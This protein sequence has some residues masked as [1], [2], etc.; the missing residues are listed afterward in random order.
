MVSRNGVSGS[1][2][3]IDM[4]YSLKLGSKTYMYHYKCLKKVFDVMEYV[5]LG[6]K[7]QQSSH[8]PVFCRGAAGYKSSSNQPPSPTLRVIG[9]TARYLFRQF[10]KEIGF[11]QINTE[12]WFRLATPTTSQI[13]YCPLYDAKTLS[14]YQQ[15]LAADNVGMSTIRKALIML[16]RSIA[17]RY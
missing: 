4:F 2:Q 13:C 14:T 7:Q 12:S 6:E 11:R 5:G 17:T 9:L 3:C 8:V 15:K 1:A 16:G 10:L